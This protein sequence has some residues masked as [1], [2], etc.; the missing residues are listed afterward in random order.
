[1][2]FKMGVMFRVIPVMIR[3]KIKNIYKLKYSSVL[4]AQKTISYVGM[5]ARSTAPLTMIY[6]RKAMIFLIP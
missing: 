5:V 6:Y 1:M 2:Y 3:L 4:S